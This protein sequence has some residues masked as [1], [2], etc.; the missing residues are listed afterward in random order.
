MHPQTEQSNLSP[1]RYSNRPSGAYKMLVLLLY[2]QYTYVTRAPRGITVLDSIRKLARLLGT[3]S[4]NVKQWLEFLESVGY[5]ESLTYTPNMR[6]AK[7]KLREPSNV[8]Y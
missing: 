8:I 6:S 2:G 1:R 7:F 4:R 5:L 3:D